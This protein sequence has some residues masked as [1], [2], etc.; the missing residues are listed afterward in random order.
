MK[1]D[2]KFLQRD[3]TA[4]Q[5]EQFRFEIFSIAYLDEDCSK[6]SPRS[7]MDNYKILIMFDGSAQIFMGKNIYYAHK[8]D[9]VIFAPGSLYHAEIAKGD[10]CRFISINFNLL[11]VNVRKEFCKIL[12]LKDIVIYPKLVSDVMVD[13]MVTVY[14]QVKNGCPDEYYRIDLM[15]KKLISL[16]AYDSKTHISGEIVHAVSA[17]EE[18]IVLK[19]SQYIINNPSLDVNVQ[20][21]CEYC[22]VSQ[23]YLY[24]CFKSVLG[25]STKLFITRAK[26]NIAQKMLLQTDKSISAIAAQTGF[27]NGYHFSNVFKSI[28]GISPSQYRKNCP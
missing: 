11:S 6:K 21:L 7:V 26:M 14:N 17:N 13:Y 5:L 23:S 18:L 27:C 9:C 15:L 3:N 28:Y 12:N 4:F 16:I 1:T 22:N 8:G 19:C 2:I 25:I 10:R 24:K 20:H